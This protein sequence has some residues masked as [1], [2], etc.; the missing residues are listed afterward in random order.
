MVAASLIVVG[1]VCM[2]VPALARD[3]VCGLFSCADQ[4]PDIAVLR[5]ATGTLAVLVPTGTGSDV[6]SVR[7]LQ[8]SAGSESGGGTQQWRI[9]RTAASD[10]D[11]Y[12]IGVQPDGFRT[13]T[14]LAE[15]P[16]QDVWTAEV[17][18]RCT[19]ASLPFEP[20][21]LDPGK[22]AAGSEAATEH[23][24]RSTAASAEHCETSAGTLERILFFTG[25][26]LTFAGAVLGIVLVFSRPPKV[27]DDDWM[28]S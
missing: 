4:V 8:G 19:V 23:E 28:E 17:S 26:L 21:S 5:E 6:Q 25:M 12:Q 27:G 16:S 22:V 20:G 18:F 15:Q 24:Y 10:L 7:V 1:V 13:T 2:T 11:A 9:Q 14:K 3:G